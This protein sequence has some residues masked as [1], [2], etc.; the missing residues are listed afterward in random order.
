MPFDGPV[1]PLGAV[2]E[3]HPISA[4]N[5]TRLH[6]FLPKVLPGIFFGYVLYARRIWKGDIPI[7]DIEELEQRTN[8]KSNPEGSMLKK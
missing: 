6:Q 8:L 4:K 3:Y 2:V 7:A 1:I 5:L